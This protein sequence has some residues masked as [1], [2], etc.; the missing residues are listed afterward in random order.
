MFQRILFT[1]GLVLAALLSYGQPYSG[2][3]S[4]DGSDDFA[5]RSTAAAVLP[6]DQD[7]TVEGWIRTCGLRGCILDA[8]DPLSGDGL[9]IN[10]SGGSAL[11]LR[12]QGGGISLDTLLEVP[13]ISTFW[14]H[15]ALTWNHSSA[16]AEL[17]LGGKPFGQFSAGFTPASVF[18]LGRD[19]A[20]SGDYF[21]GYLEEFRVS[22]TIRY[23]GPFNPNG[24][25]SPDAATLGLWHF[26]EPLGAAALSD[27]SGM[28]HDLQPRMGATTTPPFAVSGGGAIC[29][30]AELAVTASGGVSYTWSPAEGLDDPTSPNPV[31][32]PEATT[33]YVVSATDSNSCVSLGLVVVEV[34][35]EPEAIAT[36]AQPL[37][38]A[39]SVTQLFAEGGMTFLWSTGDISQ[40]PFV[41]P[42][43]STTYSV[44]VTDAFGCSADAS[45]TVEVE[46]CETTTGLEQAS[47]F[48]IQMGPNPTW[49]SL[50]L[51]LA[52]AQPGQVA[53]RIYDS[54]GALVRQYSAERMAS[55]LH[56]K[57][58]ETGLGTGNYYLVLDLDSEQHSRPFTVLR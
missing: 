29:P 28:G 24:P 49:G 45:V 40:N 17:F 32:S 19:Q 9:A 27:A 15:L 21:D 33:Y 54:R 48:S 36:A 55:G 56:Q 26:D 10:L 52:L 3:L 25:F 58:L 50:W 22:N 31:A 51:N 43:A 47:R 37:I 7:F 14:Q 12:V 38:C 4:L 35:P 11:R 34:R 18:S 1:T 8:R 16:T 2:Y 57:V 5:E 20:I 41:S 13:L 6:A 30:G 53:M 23:T 39:G 42:E 46:E 44:T